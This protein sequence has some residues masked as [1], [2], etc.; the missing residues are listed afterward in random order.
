MGPVARGFIIM[1]LAVFGTATTAWLGGRVL[2]RVA[3]PDRPRRRDALR[4]RW[5]ILR[6]HIAEQRAWL[7]IAARG[8]GA[9]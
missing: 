1:F 4:M 8:D 5:A 6:L 7:H 2:A 9:Q 3:N